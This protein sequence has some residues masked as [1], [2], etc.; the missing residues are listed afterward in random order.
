MLD[1]TNPTVAERARSI[2]IARRAGF[3]V[4]GYYFE[5]DLGEALRGNAPRPERQRIPPKG[6]AGTFKK[7]QPPSRAEGFDALYLVRIE[8]PG[9]FTVREIDQRGAEL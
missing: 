5:T 4:I 1:N 3:R 2:A 9:T 6:I 8:R 7:L